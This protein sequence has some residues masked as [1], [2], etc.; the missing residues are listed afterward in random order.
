MSSTLP[1]GKIVIDSDATEFWERV[2]DKNLSLQKCSG[3][4]EVRYPPRPYCPECLS[5]AFDWVP[6]SGKAT[7]HSFVVY[8]HAFKPELKEALPYVAVLVELPEGVRMWSNLVN[9]GDHE[10]VHIGMPVELVYDQVGSE[11]IFRFEP[12]S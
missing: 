7:V 6:V 1:V 5:D 9:F 2:R 10:R 11:L 8:E 4:G 12:A 3:C